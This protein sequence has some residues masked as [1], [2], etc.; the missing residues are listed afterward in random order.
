MRGCLVD[1]LCIG[2]LLGSSP[3][4]HLVIPAFLT[5]PRSIWLV[6]PM[7]LAMIATSAVC[8]LRYRASGG[9]TLAS[10]ALSIVAYIAGSLCAIFGIG[11]IPVAGL[12]CA[13]ALVGVGVVVLA[14]AETRVAA[15]KGL[16]SNLSLIGSALLVASLLGWAYSFLDPAFARVVLAASLLCGCALLLVR[17]AQRAPVADS[18][19]SSDFS[20]GSLFQVMGIPLWGLFAYAVFLKPGTDATRPILFGLDEE[21]LLYGV[22]AALLL[23][24]GLSRPKKP[25]YAVLYRVFVPACCIV[26]LVLL[27]FPY[28][29][30][31][32][33][34]VGV[35]IV[36]VTSFIA[37]LALCIAFT[38]AGPGDVPAAWAVCPLLAT[39]A[40]GRLCS[41]G[42]HGYALSLANEYE[43]YQVVMSVLLAVI[44]VLVL[45]QYR[46]AEVAATNTVGAHKGE[47]AGELIAGACRRLSAEKGLSARET[48]VF[49]FMARGYAP[50]YIADALVISD[51]T[52][53]T[54][55]KN[56]YRKLGISS[57]S[58][59]LSLVEHTL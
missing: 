10:V 47:S 34:W 51:S 19:A 50:A 48:E 53:R 24:I 44:L 41:L 42:I 12:V 25:L 38:V 3:A 49:T 22:A 7:A 57:R 1:A 8:L 15:K 28:G 35:C 55:V 54:H 52:A 56:I 31:P 27:G 37:Q 33:V 43:A 40:I 32:H 2:L 36:L 29:S 9:P 21:L 18:S 58:E 46:A 13:G 26:I 39:C 59:L 4:A 16:T 14:L 30:L 20:A 23:A 11:L 6:V 45:F 5:V 17:M